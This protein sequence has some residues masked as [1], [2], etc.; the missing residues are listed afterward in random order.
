MTTA[1]SFAR[2]IVLPWIFG[3]AHRLL[4]VFAQGD[5]KSS[6]A[7]HRLSCSWRTCCRDGDHVP[8][9]ALRPFS[10]SHLLVKPM[11]ALFAGAGLGVLWPSPKMF[12]PVLAPRALGDPKEDRRVPFTPTA[13]CKRG[14]PMG[15]KEVLFRLSDAGLLF[16]E[17]LCDKGELV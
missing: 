1:P 4:G 12:V 7:P 13:L 6:V 5:L 10:Y 11:L 16:A 15:E 3:N 9:D 14:L 8:P 17:P 2:C